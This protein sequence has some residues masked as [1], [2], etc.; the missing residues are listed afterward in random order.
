MCFNCCTNAETHLPHLPRPLQTKCEKYWESE[1]NEPFKPG[2][3]LSV[4]TLSCDTHPEFELRTMKVEK[5]G[6]DGH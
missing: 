6:A 3:D 5:V 1:L 4:T 2:R